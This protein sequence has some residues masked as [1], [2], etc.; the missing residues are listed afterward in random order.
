MLPASE[1][2]EPAEIDLSPGWRFPV[3][4]ALLTAPDAPLLLVTSRYRFFVITARQLADLEQI[5]QSIGDLHQ[6]AQREAVT[7]VADWTTT[8]ERERLLIVTSTGFARAYPLDTLRPG[9]EG[10]VPMQFD[11]PLPGVPV[12]LLGASR[13]QTV[14]VVTEGGRGVRWSLAD[15]PLTGVQAINC[16]QGEAFDRVT[17]ATVL[18]EGDELLLLLEDGYARRLKAE[19]VFAPPKP[20]AKGRS[21]T[22]RSAAVADI[23]SCGRITFLTDRRLATC[24]GASLPLEASTKTY[25][26][27]KLVE[28]ERVMVAVREAAAE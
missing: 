16:G 20:N 26:L 13:K 3:R 1:W 12:L 8:R 2:A 18:D 25:P 10:P 17:A 6:L 23:T 14:A 22:A 11:N 19:S 21:L 15:I 7:A 5:G 4:Q 28:G 27:L 24:E 9:I